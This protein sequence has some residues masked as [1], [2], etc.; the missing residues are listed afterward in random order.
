[1]GRGQEGF[2]DRKRPLGEP[3]RERRP[4]DEFH[5]DGE[6]RLPEPAEAP[7]RSRP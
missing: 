6:N 7:V 3:V 2:I 1:M 4:L 5:H